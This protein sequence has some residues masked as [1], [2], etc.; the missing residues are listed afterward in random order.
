MLKPNGN[1]RNLLIPTVMERVA[2]T[3]AAIVLTPLVESELGANTFAY[4]QGLSR[5]TAA[6][7]IERLRNLGYNW[8]VDADIRSFFDTVDHPLLFQRFREFCDD[9]ELLKLI[10][11]WLTAEIV[12]DHII[13]AAPGLFSLFYSSRSQS[14]PSTTESGNPIAPSIFA[15]RNST[16]LRIASLRSAPLR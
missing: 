3:A 10:E 7:E 11:R 15:A 16:P 1:L 14:D 13:P 9:E 6:R 4:R 8:V 5:M 12:D 2:Q